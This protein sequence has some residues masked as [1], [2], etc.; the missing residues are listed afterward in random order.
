MELK[1]SLN[2]FFRIFLSFPEAE[3]PYISSDVKHPVVKC[4]WRRKRATKGV[5][6][7]EL[8]SAKSKS[9]RKSDNIDNQLFFWIA[10]MKVKALLADFG[11]FPLHQDNVTT[12]W[13]LVGALRTV[14]NGFLGKAFYEVTELEEDNEDRYEMWVDKLQIIR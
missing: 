6:N 7:G 10:F 4:P 14:N 13:N 1:S 9:N 12:N 8:S 3:W 11:A 2:F 5:N